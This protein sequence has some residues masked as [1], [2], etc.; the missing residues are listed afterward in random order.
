MTADAL[1][2]PTLWWFIKYERLLCL[3]NINQNIILS[4]FAPNIR[5]VLYVCNIFKWQRHEGESLNMWQCFAGWSS[6]AVLLS[7]VAFFLPEPSEMALCCI[8][9]LS[10]KLMRGLHLFHTQ[11]ELASSNDILCCKYWK[12]FHEGI[13]EFSFEREIFWFLHNGPIHLRTFDC[14]KQGFVLVWHDLLNAFTLRS[15]PQEITFI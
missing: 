13:Q 12:V 15:W 3:W 8:A 1:L 7:Y 2:I 6:T 11:P 10:L 14:C 5:N 4:V 9:R